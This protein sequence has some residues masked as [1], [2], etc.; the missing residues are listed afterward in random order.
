MD[1]RNTLSEP[2]FRIDRVCALIL[3]SLL[4]LP[5]CDVFSPGSGPGLYAGGRFFGKT[6]AVSGDYAV[7]GASASNE[8]F[9]YRRDGD[10]WVEDG[11]GTP[12]PEVSDDPDFALWLDIDGA[13]AVVG[14]PEFVPDLTPELRGFAYVYE[15]D[16]GDWTRTAI[17]Q[18][19][20][21]E[22][23]A[24][25]GARV[26]ISGARIAIAAP[27]ARQ[28]DTEAGS[29]FIYEREGDGWAL[30]ARLDSPVVYRGPSG[31]RASYGGALLDGDRMAVAGT[32]EPSPGVFTRAVFL[33]R[34]DGSEW[35]ETGVIPSPTGIEGAFAPQAFSGQTLAVIAPG[36]DNGDGPSGALYVYRE[37]GG[38]WVQEA[39]I[40]SPP[41][42]DPGDDGYIGYAFTA[43]ATENRV[44]TSAIYKKDRG[45]VYS[46]V[47]RLDGTWEQEAFIER[48]GASQYDF[49]GEDVAVD[50]E[51]LFVG[52]PGVRNDRGAAFVFERRGSAWVQ[53]E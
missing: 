46:Y 11:R 36:R 50:G 5:G 35:V 17:P 29:V 24:S 44:V 21:L 52:A 16:G 48:N 19:S 41:A 25:F 12:G 42:E 38:A 37:I 43:A 32:A 6:V 14:A 2:T 40:S 45:A 8:V 33:Y 27:S 30:S 4:C 20:T 7:V 53:T 10:R 34:W 28:G 13:T 18:P 23:G 26:S 15:R 49:F 47:R 39:D 1:T 3:L 9:F 51:T 31:R 22:H